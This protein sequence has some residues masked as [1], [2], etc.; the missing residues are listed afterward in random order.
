MGRCGALALASKN[1]EK[2]E[3][4]QHMLV[5]YDGLSTAAV[6]SFLFMNA[7]EDSTTQRVRPRGK[8]DRYCV[9]PRVA[10]G[11]LRFL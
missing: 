1:Q 4:Q 5:V 7:G 9:L 10:V 11:P 3:N 2:Q 8:I 6:M